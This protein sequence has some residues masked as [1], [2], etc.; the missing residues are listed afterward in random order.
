M[1][2]STR[3]LTGYGLD[4][5]FYLAKEAGC[6]GIDLSIN[7]DEYDTID[8][9]YLKLLTERHD[10]PVVS[11]TAPNRKVTKK[12]SEEIAKIADMLGVKL[13]NFTPPHRTDKE[14]EWFD[15]GLKNLAT[16]YE[17]TTI[18]IVN[19]PPKTW[20]FI[21]SEYGDA[22]PETIKKMT[23][24]T[25]LSIENVEPESGVDLIKTFT[26]L[27]NTIGLVYLSDKT[28]EKRGLFPG[29][30]DMPLE[31]LLI[32]MGEAG[33]DGYFTLDID[34]ESLSIGNEKVVIERIMEAEE[35]LQRYFNRG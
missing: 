8:P 24:H 10:V 13:I 14:K 1:L 32:R 21:I 7:F 25:A 34:P 20:L 6:S 18:N 35:Y 3:S 29:E 22:R 5:I 30:G 26:L 19:A 2:L 33:Y 23:E 28:E 31:S 12:Q 4:K 9:V 15:E 17:G 11:I 27:G 16:K